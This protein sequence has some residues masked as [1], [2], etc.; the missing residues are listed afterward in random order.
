MPDK[1]DRI[2]LR[3]SIEERFGATYLRIWDMSLEPKEELAMYRL[4]QDGSDKVLVAA[5]ELRKAWDTKMETGLGMLEVIER[6]NALCTTLD[7]GTESDE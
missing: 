3:T 7:E 4:D 6:F 1:P 5:R 2:Y